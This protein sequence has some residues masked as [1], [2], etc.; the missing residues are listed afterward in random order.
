MSRRK[1]KK[2][3][4]TSNPLYRW[5][6]KNKKSKS[7]TSIKSKHKGGYNV[8]RRKRSTRRRSGF[9]GFNMNR[10]LKAGVF[11]VAAAMIAPRF[12]QGVD[13]KLASAAAGFF[14]GNIPGAVVGYLAPDIV[15]NVL[16][17]SGGTSNGIILH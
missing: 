12:I 4:G 7:R 1:K 11:G 13:P 2:A 15:G 17:G 3:W 5:I 16:G 14:A 10:L 6:K 8:A 9:G